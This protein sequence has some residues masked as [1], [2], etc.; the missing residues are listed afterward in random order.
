[1]LIGALRTQYGDPIALQVVAFDQDSQPIFDG[2]AAGY[3][4][5]QDAALIARGAA[6]ASN[7]AQ[8]LATLGTAA[9]PMHRRVIVVTDAVMTAGPET[10]ALVAAIRAL[11]IDRLDVVLAGGIR[12]DRLAAA[13]VRTGL[14]HAGDVYDLD[15][16][17]AAVAAGL[18]EPVVADVAIDVPG[19]TWVYPR[20]VP[21][22]RPGTPVMVYARLAQPARTLDVT[23][24]GV[25]HRIELGAAAPALVERALARAEIEQ[26]EHTLEIAP[27]VDLPQLRA[28]LA[29]RSVAARVVSSQTAML[30]L[31][32][33]A[34][35]ARYQIDRTALADV[36][37][38]GPAGLE[39]THRTAAW[40]AARGEGGAATGPARGAGQDQQPDP[41]VAHEQAREQVRIA[42]QRDPTPA[43]ARAQAIEQARAAGVLGSSDMHG[44]GAYAAR[45][46]ATDYSSGFDDSNIYGGLLG[47]AAGEVSGGYGY[48]RAGFG[49][50][51]GG[52]GEGT[53]GLGRY[54][55]IGHGAGVG[56]GYGVGA[57]HGG[58]RGRVPAMPTVAIGQPI[59]AAGGLDRSIIRRYIKRNTQ[60]IQYCYERQLFAQ[61][62]LAGVLTTQFLIEPTGIVKTVTAT[63]V[64]P[65][66]AS[67][68]ADVIKTIE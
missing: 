17:S 49:P 6:G 25:A 39:Q 46:T 20:V 42:E 30:V 58:M 41:A 10:P 63:G 54:G 47:D 14:P 29:K 65:S 51:G 35:Y 27:A 13:I 3:G 37:V 43:E 50:G 31:E 26:L 18:G 36:L 33:D 1:A 2:P 56:V 67:C 19:A 15:R 22:A 5:A 4:S 53:I 52:T 57:G 45:A 34:D 60:K 55:T 9:R 38:V 48:G 24:G 21:S 44:E 64:D 23:I 68:V 32:T 7:L 59:V 40:L 66:V 12:D 11:P 16:G 8:V 62:M 28:R 61:P